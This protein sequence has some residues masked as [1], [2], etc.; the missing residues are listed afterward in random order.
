[1]DGELEV[2]PDDEVVICGMALGHADPAAPENAL[3]TVR[4]PVADFAMF[5]G[6]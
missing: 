2:V 5:K 1:V 6:F 3:E 4:E